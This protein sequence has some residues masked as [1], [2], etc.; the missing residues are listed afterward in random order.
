MTISK[1]STS[2][3]DYIFR[4]MGFEYLGRED[5][6]QVKPMEVPHKTIQRVLL[7]QL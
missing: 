3:V 2:I 1:N 6:V 5:L 7:S 4:L